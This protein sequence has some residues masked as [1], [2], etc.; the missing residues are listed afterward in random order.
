MD[1]DEN[2]NN[3]TQT[4]PIQ[5]SEDQTDAIQTDVSYTDPFQSSEIDIDSII[6]KKPSRTQSILS[7]VL[8]ILGS[9]I[10]INI[11]FFFIAMLFIILG[12]VFASEPGYIITCSLIAGAGIALGITSIILGSKNVKYYAVTSVFG[13]ISGII[14]VIVGILDISFFFWLDTNL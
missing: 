1:N 11:G 5:S 9:A 10:S 4:N 3:L 14:A 2:L 13:I 7:L 6:P 8:G 12:F